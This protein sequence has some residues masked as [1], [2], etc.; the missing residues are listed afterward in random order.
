MSIIVTD[1]NKLYASQCN[2][3]YT[4]YDQ[5]AASCPAK[6]YTCETAFPGVKY[7][8]TKGQTI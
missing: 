2:A 6:G 8:L 3:Y 4:N 5:C 1:P 7:T